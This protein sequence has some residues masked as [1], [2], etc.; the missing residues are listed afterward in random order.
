MDEQLHAP[1]ALINVA[2]EK[3]EIPHYET[4]E[5]AL[6]R[7]IDLRLIPWLTLLYFVNYLVRMNIGIKRNQIYILHN[8]N[9]LFYFF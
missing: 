8:R 9:A 7:K 1:P 5:K 4:A 6:L 3:E 2:A